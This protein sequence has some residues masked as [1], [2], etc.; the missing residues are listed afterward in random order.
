MSATTRTLSDESIPDAGLSGRCRDRSGGT[1]HI[2]GAHHPVILHH[3]D[4]DAAE[5]AGRHCAVR[6]Y[7]ID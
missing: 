5:L 6:E 2:D 4:R 3:F 7:S 1:K